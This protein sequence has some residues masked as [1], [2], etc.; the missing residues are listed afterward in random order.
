MDDTSPLP[1][2]PTTGLARALELL[3]EPVRVRM[4]DA[5][6]LDELTVNELVRILQLPQPTVSRHLKALQVA[7]W[8][9]RRTVGTAT[10]TRLDPAHLSEPVATLIGLVRDDPARAAERDADRARQ[11]LVLAEREADA[12]AFFSRVA[13]GWDSLRDQLFGRQFL[14]STMAALL[15]RGAAVVDLGCGPGEVLEL[16]APFAARVTGIDREPSMLA[17]A[18]NRLA[19]HSNV[20]LH[21]ALLERLPLPDA[22][23]DIALL[24]LVLHHLAAPDAALREAARILRD[25][26]RL[27]VVDMQPHTSD[28]LRTFGHRHRGFSRD[29]LGAFAAPSGLFVDRYAALRPDGDAQGPPLF[30]A[31]L[32]RA[33]SHAA[34]KKT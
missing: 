26:G 2:S 1:A 31:T 19:A 21:E 8:L 33:A 3:S 9:Q 25:D 12:G 32:V 22:S 15:P 20:A 13:S 18:R 24:V 16:L 5:L 34:A 10:L 28:V 27:I 11:A 30:I 17:A 29:T 7:G 4:V 14:A 23:A 6:A